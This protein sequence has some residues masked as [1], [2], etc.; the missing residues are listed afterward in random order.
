[1]RDNALVLGAYI[2]AEARQAFGNT[3]LQITWISYKRPFWLKK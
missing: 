1:M 2:M 3:A